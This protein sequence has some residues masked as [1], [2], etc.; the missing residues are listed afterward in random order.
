ML[1][2]QRAMRAK[3]NIVVSLLTQFV[4]LVCGL[5]VPRLMIGTFGSEAYGATASI[6]N[7]LGYITLLEGGIG[8]VARAALYKPLA[9]NDSYGISAV[10]KEIQ[11]FFRIIAYIFLLYV[12]ILA[13]GFKSIS[14]IECFDGYTT[15]LL[16]VV[17]SIA[18]FA[19]YF[20]GISYS[21]LIQA[22]QKNY[23]TQLISIAAIILNTIL[24]IFLIRLNFSLI[25]VKFVSSLVFASKPILM[26]LYVKKSY[27]LPRVNTR[28]SHLLSQKWTGLGQH[29]AFF[30][31]SNTDVAV[32]TFFTDLKTVAVYAVYHMVISHIQSVTTSFISGA[33]ALFGDMIAKKEYDQLNRT[34][35]YYETLMSFVSVLL[36]SVTA[37]L[38]VPF[39]RV[40]TRNVNDANYIS[41]FFAIMLT[42][43][44]LLYCLRQPY[45]SVTIAAGHFKQTKFAAYGEAIINITLSIVLVIKY[46]LI[47]VAIGTVCAVSFRFIFYVVYLSRNIMRRSIA[48]FIRRMIVNAVSFMVIFGIGFVVQSL[49]QISDYATWVI[50]GVIIT[51]AAIVVMIVF[52]YV[53][54]REDLMPVMKRFK[55]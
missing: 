37:S 8:G 51:V 22:A 20:I 24:T 44:S 3:L 26:W 55:R 9:D 11:R 5:I 33:E 25:A 38:I 32:L 42:L 6:S 40:Y 30:L 49:V 41:P 50:A 7:F 45:H 10:I 17:I 29:I 4:T 36:Y 43:A 34:F 27:N 18:T 54:Y 13:F 31:H 39:V 28:N 21:V 47:G 1:D 35:R 53:F 46:S 2:R 14:H 12:I 16:V 52:T 23:I 19:Q 15:F 48:L